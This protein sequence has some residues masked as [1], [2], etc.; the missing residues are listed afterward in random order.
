MAT[1]YISSITL[2]NGD[3][4]NLVDKSSGYTTNA[5]TITGIT[6]NGV[7]Q[8]T[9]GVVDLGNVLTGNASDYVLTSNLGTAIQEECGKKV[10][11]LS[12]NGSS[13]SASSVNLLE[14]NGT[15]LSFETLAGYWIPDGLEVLYVQIL[16]EATDFTQANARLFELTDLD[17]T[18]ASV[19]LTCVEDGTMYTA[20]LKDTGN[21]LGGMMSSQE[22][23]KK[24]R[25][26]EVSVMGSGRYD[27]TSLTQNTVDNISCFQVWL[28]DGSMDGTPIN[29]PDLTGFATGAQGIMSNVASTYATKSE[30]PTAT[31][32]LTNDSGYT[33]NTG[34]VTSVGVSNAT[35]GGLSVSG[36]P[37]TGSGTITVGHSNVLTSAQTTQAVYPIKIDKNGHISAYGTAATAS[38][39]GALANSGGEVT[40]DIVLKS[41][42]ATNSPSIIFQRGT[43][44][45]NYND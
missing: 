45:D 2:P 30:V 6:M 23:P 44:T 31:S 39:V 38:D 1:K 40:G 8:G 17:M 10:A 18:T 34:T 37:V 33:T 3:I 32:Q 35:N 26:G 27:I 4:A 5:G 7:N 9:S 19:R 29:L 25:V 22:I 16:N 14:G 15:S 12:V 13:G 36:S 42:A 21:G 24:N 28:D 11:I 41:A 43:L 20:E